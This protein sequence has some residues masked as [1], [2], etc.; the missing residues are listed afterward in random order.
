MSTFVNSEA[1][2]LL[3]RKD[4]TYKG[5]KIIAHK[6]VIAKLAYSESRQFLKK[7]AETQDLMPIQY[8]V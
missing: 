6:S 7:K 8:I 3:D 1:K 4:I 2:K 5:K